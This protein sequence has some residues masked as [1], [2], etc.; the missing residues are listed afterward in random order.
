MIERRSP[1]GVKSDGK[2]VQTMRVSC[3]EK[4]D[5]TYSRK[6]VEEREKKTF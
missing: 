5:S 6:R 4:V 3:A 1:S 2:N